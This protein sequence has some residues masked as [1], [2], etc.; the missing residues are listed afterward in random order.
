MKLSS[1]AFSIAMLFSATAMATPVNL[2]TN[3]NFDTNTIGGSSFM[4]GG[5]GV[6]NWSATGLTYLFYPYTA[7]TTGAPVYSSTFLLSGPGN[8]VNNGF[9]GVSPDGGNFIGLD[10]DANYRSSISQTVSGLTVGGHYAVSF[11]WAAAQ[12]SGFTGPTT[13]TMQVS[14]GNDTRLTQTINN[15]STGF[16]GWVQ[17]TVI[18]DATSTSE[19]L[20]FLAIGTPVGLPPFSLLDGVTMTVPEPES[21]TM[22]APGLIGLLAFRRRKTSAGSKA[23]A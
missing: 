22:L 6:T 2:V 17:S 18:F 12:Q 8:G 9:T 4:Y 1:I 10:G 3:G 21:W 20:N 5:S 13:E 7:D 15:V 11:Y 19:V 14:L 23:A 16:N